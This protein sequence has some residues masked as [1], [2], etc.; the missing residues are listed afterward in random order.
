[1]LRRLPLFALGWL[2]TTLTWVLVLVVESR[3]VVTPGI[4][5][6]AAQALLL[7]DVRAR[8][9]RSPTDDGVRGI[10]I[11]ACVALG[12]S[13]TL[14]F[15]IAGG[16]AESLAFVLLTLFLAAALLFA[17]GWR[18]EIVLVLATLAVGAAA[19]PFTTQVI[20]ASAF[21]AAVLIGTVM[22]LAIAEGSARAFASGVRLRVAE[23]ERRRE[24]AESR[25]AYRDL[26]ENAR[27]FIYTGDLSGRLTYV[28]EAMAA[29]VG[30]PVS[31]IVGRR[32]HDFVVA[33][34]ESADLETA[35]GAIAAGTSVPLLPFA[36][37]T[38]N[39]TR[40]VEALASAIRGGD[41][42]D[43]AIVGVRGIAR[44]VT[45]RMHAA[46]ALRESEERFRTSFDSASTGIVLVGTDG[47]ISQ[48]NRA[49]CDMMGY[50]ETE[51]LE[52][53]FEMLTHPDDIAPT[54][55]RASAALHGGAQSYHLEKRY[56]HKRGHTVW[57]LLSSAL[58][59]DVHGEPRYFIS[60]IQDI[61]ERK[62]A[63]EA[64]RASELR[65][66]GL[67][68]SHHDLIARFDTALQLTFVNDAYCETVGRSREEL[69]GRSWLPLVE[70]EHRRR[71]LDLLSSIDLP[72]YRSRADVRIQTA[73]GERWIAWESF[74]I[75]DHHGNTVEIQAAGRDV[76]ERRAAEEAL[77]ASLEELRRSE[78]RLRLLA[79]HQATIREEER[80]RLGFDLHDNVC[81][82]LLGIAM[83]IESLR[84]RVSP[85][86]DSTGAELDR[87]VRYLNELVEHLRML[88]RDMRPMQLRDL[89]LEGCLR[90]LVDAM[91]SAHARVS[92]EFV[93]A[94][95]RLE[96]EV[97][98]AVYRIAQEALANAARH[99][100]AGAIAV[101]LA[102]RDGRIELVV[103][104]DG[105]GFDVDGRRS[106][107][108]GLVSMRE[109]ALAL[110]GRFEVMSAPGDGTVVR[111][112]CPAVARAAA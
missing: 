12:A 13:S 66:R 57:G 6:F 56:R 104:D 59:R 73:Q 70:P 31:A 22:S 75:K 65:Y 92:V 11:G 102:A 36:V 85:L 50:D 62:L 20:A 91:A 67:V 86:A 53:G 105:R 110:G 51:V 34:P 39:G 90:S 30:A 72:P 21:A 99:A 1:M 10:L 17:W 15:A 98:I 45:D 2:A 46:R 19:L 96:E 24:L 61:T 54:V 78:E 87:I 77:R 58:V 49:F 97:E 18:A 80:K 112:E 100:A 93:G 16:G 60:Q 64:L 7:I 83:L 32:F 106:R 88:A 25:D 44:D 27:D 52:Q 89:G 26:A 81:Q 42:A 43:R 40:W 84:R 69:L 68:E 107:A 82:E 8:A 28:N 14:L 9:G 79:Q 23:L 108:L 48:V 4:L 38:A 103:R 111:L 63:E 76:T 33:E 37:R 101:T 47:R 109:R 55:E 71:L 41:G 74:A 3:R 94:I 5:T 29:F 95:P 35:L